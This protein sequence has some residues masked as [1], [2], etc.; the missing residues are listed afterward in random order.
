MLFY[1]AQYH[2]GYIYLLICNLSKRRGGGE[3]GGR[4]RRGRG[5][6]G[7]GKKG[8]RVL[9]LLRHQTCGCKEVFVYVFCSLALALHFPIKLQMVLHNRNIEHIYP[10]LNFS[11]Q[12]IL[13]SL[14][15]TMLKVRNF[16][17]KV[18]VH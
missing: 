7:R 3:G 14:G 8:G 9:N 2:P 18:R 1:R 4:E 10:S 16:E 15:H 17:K 13:N 12:Y 5:E 11:V 6:R